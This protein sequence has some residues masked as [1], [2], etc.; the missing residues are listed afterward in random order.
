MLEICLAPKVEG[1]CT[2]KLARWHF[3]SSTKACKPFYYTGC[4]GNEN[5]FI[6]KDD[7]Q[8]KCPTVI[9]MLTQLLLSNELF[10]T[11]LNKFFTWHYF[12]FIE[13][14]ACHQPYEAGECSNYSIQWFYDVEQR[15]CRQFYYGGCG[16]N[17]NR[18]SSQYE[19][20][21]TCER[22]PTTVA[23]T[24]PS[25][26]TVATFNQGI[27]KINSIFI[28]I[29][30]V[31]LNISESCNLNYDVGRDCNRQRRIYFDFYTGECKEFIYGGCEGNSNNFKTYEECY[32]S[33]GASQGKFNTHFLL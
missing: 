31:S 19:C 26:L 18:F 20:Q 24:Q 14:E 21:A 8:H 5:N 4:G 29:S 11:F 2:E 10:L 30:T 25:P 3:D 12:M 9:G 23:P 22:I 15:Q 32:D 16:G 1:N 7:C 6:S 27:Y 33:C 28:S 13:R 17:K